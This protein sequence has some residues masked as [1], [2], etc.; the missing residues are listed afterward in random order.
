MDLYKA[1]KDLYEQ[2]KRL[3]LVIAS[4]EEIE[5]SG[6]TIPAILPKRRGRPPMDAAARR[7]V[8][9]RMKRYWAKRRKAAKDSCPASQPQVEPPAPPPETSGIS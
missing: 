6:K 2:K 4:L 8:S 3:D 7:E 5:R 1:I 9:E